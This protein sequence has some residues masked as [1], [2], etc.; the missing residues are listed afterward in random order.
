MYRFISYNRNKSFASVTCAHTFRPWNSQHWQQQDPS[1]LKVK[2][3]PL[4]GKK[5]VWKNGIRNGKTL[6][7]QFKKLK[8]TTTELRFLGVMAVN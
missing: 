3:D 8:P 2:K 6:R 5:S 7:S 1:M 4:N